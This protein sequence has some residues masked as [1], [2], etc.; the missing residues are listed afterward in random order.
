MGLE[1]CQSPRSRIYRRPSPIPHK[2]S[3]TWG[4]IIVDAFFEL[5]LLEERPLPAA[6]AAAAAEGGRGE[7]MREEVRSS[8]TVEPQQP[9]LARSSSPPATP[10]ARFRLFFFFFA[11]SLFD[12]ECARFGV[13]VLLFE[14]ILRCWVSR[15][16]NL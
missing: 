7:G 13:V 1:V 15:V 10:A 12:S 11:F 4:K 5:P 3:K 2:C 8:G 16:S 14:S 9:R 6:A